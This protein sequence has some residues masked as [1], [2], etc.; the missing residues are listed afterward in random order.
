MQSEEQRL[1]AGLFQRLKQAEHS[2]EIRDADA[3]RHIQSFIQQQPAAPYYMAQSILIQEAA[4]SRLHQQVQEL[5]NTVTQLKAKQKQRGVSFLSGLFGSHRYH[6]QAPT[7]PQVQMQPANYSNR[8]EQQPLHVSSRGGSFM[9]GALQTAAGIAGGM[10]LGNMLTNMFNH[11]SPEEIVH[12]LDNHTSSIAGGGETLMK[13]NFD[14][15]NLEAF[16]NVSEQ[17][18]I[19]QNDTLSNQ[20]LDAHEFTHDDDEFI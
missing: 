5:E 20:E 15:N 18:F 12:I 3:E 8:P 16:N 17:N 19:D 4:L 9:A 7:Q 10:V 13:Q 11:D 2:A 1:I 14:S 6:P